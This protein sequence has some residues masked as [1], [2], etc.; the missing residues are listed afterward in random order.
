V[1]K[2]TKKEIPLPKNSIFSD[3]KE[4]R[5]FAGPLPFTFTFNKEKKEMLIIEGVRQNWKPNPLQVE[6]YRFQ[7]VEKF[8]FSE[9]IL[10]NAFII[11]DIPYSWKKGKIDV[12]KQ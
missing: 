2:N 10:A 6:K 9:A 4:A 12:W 3:W 1:L 5:R 7:F 8:N 11:N